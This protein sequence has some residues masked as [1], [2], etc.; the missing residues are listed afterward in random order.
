VAKISFH[1][2]LPRKTPLKISVQTMGQIPRVRELGFYQ[3][4]A[5]FL[6]RKGIDLVGIQYGKVISALSTRPR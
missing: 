6:T 5:I 4:L 2:I 1:M 3:K